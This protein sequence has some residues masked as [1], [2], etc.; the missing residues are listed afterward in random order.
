M[1]IEII[2]DEAISTANTNFF[3]VTV[4]G[5][6]VLECMSQKEVESLTVKEIM[7]AYRGF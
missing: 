7:D 3:F 5:E 1:I 4:N 6:T 2:K